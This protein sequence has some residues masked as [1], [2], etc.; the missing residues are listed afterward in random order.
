MNKGRTKKTKDITKEKLI[1]VYQK[2]GSA[3]KVAEVLEIGRTTATRYLREAGITLNEPG[4]TTWNE[5]HRGEESFKWGA[6]A[7]WLRDHKDIILPRDYKC[8]VDICADEKITVDVVKSFINRR[9]HS[10]YSK[11]KRFIPFEQ[12]NV[13]MDAS[14]SAGDIFP[15]NLASAESIYFS[16]DKW[17]NLVYLT[18]MVTAKEG[19]FIVKF[20]PI[21]AYELISILRRNK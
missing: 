15:W 20:V 19:E 21:D 4:W 11:L 12:F 7:Q 5:E 9:Y 2:F 1:R 18:G 13:K 17:S 6:F 3:R 16:L 8:I 14:D 10:M